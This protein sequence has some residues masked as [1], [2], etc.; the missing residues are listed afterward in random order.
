MRRKL[1]SA[2]ICSAI[3]LSSGFV[4][5]SHDVIPTQGSLRS[6]GL[7]NPLTGGRS[8]TTSD[9]NYGS[10][11]LSWNDSLRAVGSCEPLGCGTTEGRQFLDA[12]GLCVANY[13]DGRTE[14]VDD[15]HC[16]VVERSIGARIESR[17]CEVPIVPCEGEG[18]EPPPAEPTPPEEPTYTCPAG[19][20]LVGTLCH[21]V[22]P[23]TEDATVTHSYTCNAGWTLSGTVCRRTSSHTVP[24]NRSSTYSCPSGGNWF[25]AGSTC[26]R[27]VT[28]WST[29]TGTP[30]TCAA[31]WTP[32]I[33]N[34]CFRHVTRSQ[35][36]AASHTY[37]CPAGYAPSGTT[38]CI[39]YT[40]NTTPATAVTD[41]TCPSGWT[42]S[43]SVCHGSESHVVPA[44]PG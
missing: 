19:Y 27:E 38:H 12:T 35:P 16:E 17:Y 44:I 7:H 33:A 2:S 21:G 30:P 31:G 42:L 23:V 10:A 41:R 6:L 18:V 25:L 39:G 37:S 11:V 13:L 32:T 36:A 8:D 4:F 5:A 3:L 29:A 15:E 26:Y 43:G 34:Q 14:I 28:E 40:T 22:V 24:A 9:Q 20:S 1:L